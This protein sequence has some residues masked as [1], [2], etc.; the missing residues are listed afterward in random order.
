MKKRIVSILAVLMLLA[1]AAPAASAESF[2]SLGSCEAGAETS[3]YVAPYEGEELPETENLPEGCALTIRRDEQGT[4]LN[5]EGVLYVAGSTSFAV[6]T[7][8]GLLNCSL[9]V[10]PAVPSVS[11][12][13]D[14]RCRPGE[15]VGLIAQALAADGGTLSYQ[16]YRVQG[17]MPVP[18]EGAVDSIYHPSTAEPGSASY[19]CEVINSNNGYTSSAFS[20][21]MTLT[22][23]EPTVQSLSIVT[24]PKKTSYLEGDALDPEG[25]VLLAV[26]DDGSRT[27][28]KEGYSFEPAAFPDAG[29]HNVRVSF[30]GRSCGFNV[31]VNKLEDTVEGIGVLS[32]PKKTVYQPGE[33]LQT[34]GLSIRA[35]TADGGHY[36]VSSGLDCSPTALREE[37]EQI[38]TVKYAE[39][40]CTFTVK[41]EQ[42]KT[43]TGISILSLPTNRSYTVGDR[44]DVSGLSVQL[45]T[46][47]GS[48]ALEGDYTWTP[49]VVTSPGTQEITV[50]YGKYTAKFNVTVKAREMTS[51]T[52]RPTP[53]P[54]AT[55]GAEATPAGPEAS[56]A[57][58]A[59]P[60]ATAMPVITPRVQH[61]ANGVSTLVTI[62]LVIAILALA[63]LLGYVWYMRRQ[64]FEDEGAPR[65]FSFRQWMI[66][67]LE[68]AQQRLEKKPADEAEAEAE[69]EA[70]ADADAGTEKPADA[71]DPKE[72]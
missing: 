42:A 39:Q 55:P 15:D 32:L 3:L 11:I 34:A 6:A 29:T 63:A 67:R 28:V 46:N 7:D 14:M 52:P 62:F 1:A 30:G 24:L 20:E 47:R 71:E 48:E 53:T 41:V 2:I 65:D 19:C 4:Y 37:G 69:P 35:Y 64:G 38:I 66:D 17:V 60:A 36:D 57:P 44:I 26:Y 31:R 21:T 23:S 9:E 12:T 27:E 70:E 72:N 49:K 25:L 61:R 10:N 5:F 45:N 50:I 40:V 58:S 51:P 68:R 18:I 13:G 16:W 43:V 54:A 56:A 22:V 59:S 8:E 33:S